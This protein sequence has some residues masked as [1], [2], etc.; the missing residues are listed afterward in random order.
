MGNVCRAT[1]SRKI[2]DPQLFEERYTLMDHIGE[3]GF[4]AVY[5]CVETKTGN[6]LAAKLV[7]NSLVEEWSKS[8]VDH[9][10]MEIKTLASCDHPNIIK[11]MDFF[12]YQKHSIVVME[13]PVDT[14]D[15]FNY[16]AYLGGVCEAEA[17]VIMQQIVEAVWYLHYDARI[18]HRDIKPENVLVD[19]RT[20]T[21]KLI[22]FGAAGWFHPNT[23]TNFSGTRLYAPPEVLLTGR[24]KAE[25]LTSWSLGATLYFILFSRHAFSNED[26]I[27]N[28][29]IALPSNCPLT[30]ACLHFM[31][32]SL[33]PDP[34][35]RLTVDQLN[36]HPWLSNIAFFFR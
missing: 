25:P 6:K 12:V 17:K 22:D 32:S 19:V 5:T 34:A 14:V 24:Y 20:K 21:C 2:S 16:T 10:P 3:G 4:G 29:S 27:I 11:L 9:V 7:D 15:L 36:K 8:D 35:S 31:H 33:H 18:V 28:S 13:K 26:A 1:K 23:Y 30:P